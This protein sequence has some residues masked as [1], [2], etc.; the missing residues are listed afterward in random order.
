MRNLL[1]I[2]ITALLLSSLV[3]ADE[4]ARLHGTWV[5]NTGALIVV[6]PT[7]PDGTFTMNI[8]KP[9]SNELLGQV[10]GGWFDGPNFVYRLN[11]HEIVG[12]YLADR[13]MVEVVNAST[14]WSAIW[15]RN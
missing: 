15:R 7:S 13:D 6:G 5:S 11:G 9:N 4:R 2:L 14:N 8:Y 3:S 12:V 1:I 10:Q